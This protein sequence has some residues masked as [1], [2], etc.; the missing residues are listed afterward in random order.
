MR[1]G[2]SDC[3]G[4][5][6][7]GRKG[8]LVLVLA[9]FR[10]FSSSLLL[11]NPDVF[12]GVLRDLEILLCGDGLGLTSL[13]VTRTGIGIVFMLECR[14]NREGITLVGRKGILVVIL[15]SLG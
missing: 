12:A 4:L 11:I 1:E 15:T 2:S 14:S 7:V 5:A 8:V 3:E 9:C 13:I 6:L 10:E